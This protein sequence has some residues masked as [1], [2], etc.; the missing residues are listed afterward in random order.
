MNAARDLRSCEPEPYT[1]RAKPPETVAA[2]NDDG[3]KA[4]FLAFPDFL[5]AAVMGYRLHQRQATLRYDAMKSRRRVAELVDKPAPIPRDVETKLAQASDARHKA[6]TLEGIDRW[7]NRDA[8]REHRAAARVLE[9]EARELQ[10]EATDH[11]WNRRA[12]YETTSLAMARGEVVEKTKAGHTRIMTRAGIQQ[13]YEAGYLQPEDGKR[14]SSANLYETAKRYRDAYEIIAGRTTPN[15]SEASGGMKGP[16]VRIAEAGEAL[17]VMRTGLD[18]LEVAVLD[19]VCGE[20]IRARETATILALG[21]EKV[22]KALVSG[23]TTATTNI[24]AARAVK[25]TDE[26]MTRDRLQAA[27]V[28]I[29]AA[30]RMVS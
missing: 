11:D 24:R 25:D 19:R 6:A 2:D 16:Q 4:A 23:L 21:F 28:E 20:E 30:E 13:A 8:I 12:D 3:V 26:R 22:R 15:G 7:G 27:H 29:R 9:T 1:G 5:F 18:R 17:R 14:L 10:R